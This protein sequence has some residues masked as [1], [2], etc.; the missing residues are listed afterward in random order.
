[1]GRVVEIEQPH[2]HLH[3]NKAVDVAVMLLDAP[4]WVQT[5]AMQSS[6]IITDY[7]IK[8]WDIGP[9]DAAYIVGLFSLMP[10]KRKNLPIVH[11]GHIALM[12]G[13]E[14]I[15]VK[16]NRGVLDYIEAYLVEAHALP[17]ASGSPVM[18]RP[19]IRFR[20]TAVDFVSDQDDGVTAA[21]AE[22]K[23][24]L[25]GVWVAAWPGVPD[26]EMRKALG[27]SDRTWIPVGMGIVIPGERVL[28]ILNSTALTQERHQLR[29]NDDLSRAATPTA[30]SPE[31]IR[32]SDDNSDHLEDFNRLVSAASKRKPKDDR[33]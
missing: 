9:G 15:P 19:T 25:L 10:G 4:D 28:D 12:P 20:P 18:V 26:D 2:W 13:D 32:A 30:G 7:L 23:D 16:N 21:I 24:Y 11:S 1:M 29:Q 31:T 3:S 8:Y 6:S 33:T 27:L 22:S 5:T 17:G 14:S